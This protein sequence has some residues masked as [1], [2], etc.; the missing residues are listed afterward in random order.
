MNDTNNT[1][2]EEL[3]TQVEETAAPAKEVNESSAPAP[4]EPRYSK[5][6]ILIY[7]ILA[8]LAFTVGVALITLSIW[9]KNTFDLGFKHLLYNLAAP[10]EGTGSAT[11]V[12]HISFA[13]IFSHSVNCLF[14]LLI[15]S[16]MCRSFLV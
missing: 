4:N 7:S 16:L 3:Q 9:Y 5:K 8:G 1:M 15:V 2:Q 10:V 6:R 13:Y 14:V 11:I 12:Y